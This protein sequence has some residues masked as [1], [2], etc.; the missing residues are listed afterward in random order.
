MLSAV[1][2]LF[3]RRDTALGFTRI[4]GGGAQ[5][6]DAPRQAGAARW[7]AQQPSPNV[8]PCGVA[9]R[10]LASRAQDGASFLFSSESV[11]QGHPDKMCDQVSGQS[12]GGRC[13]WA[14]WL[15]LSSTAWLQWWRWDGWAP[16]AP[17]WV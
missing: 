9:W 14:C 13:S 16:H 4:C 17:L 6:A 11:T 1:R 5:A 3:L 8:A 2:S 15:C 10:A 12:W 7:G